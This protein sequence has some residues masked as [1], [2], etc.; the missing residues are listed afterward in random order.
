ML[1]PVS[2]TA[3]RQ[4]LEE[5]IASVALPDVQGQLPKTHAVRNVVLTTASFNQ[6]KVQLRAQGLIRKERA[7]D[8][9]I[10][11]QLTPLGDQTMTRL[12]AVPRKR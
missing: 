11:W 7:P 6:L 8:G 10:R 3:M 12:V 2:E 5:Y 9:A 4:A 1:E